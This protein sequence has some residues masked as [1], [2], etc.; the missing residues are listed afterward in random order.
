MEPI[1]FKRKR[2]KKRR[3]QLNTRKRRHS[4]HKN[5]QKG[6]QVLFQVIECTPVLSISPLVVPLPKNYTRQTVHY[7]HPFG[8][9]VVKGHNIQ[10]TRAHQRDEISRAV[11]YSAVWRQGNNT[12]EEIPKVMA[13]LVHQLG[14]YVP[15]RDDPLGVPLVIDH[16]DPVDLLRVQLQYDVLD[17]I[18]PS[19]CDDG[20]EQRRGLV[21]LLKVLPDR[22]KEILGRDCPVVGSKRLK[23]AVGFPT[24]Y[25]A[26]EV[27]LDACGGS[28][29]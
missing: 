10:F 11:S 9:I 20:A 4:H 29:S 17:F 5:I 23:V 13:W 18:I 15:Q 16:V 1:F 3:E 14:D 6:A 2:K 22:G 24:S 27:C 8:T 21:L 7:S 25:N 12:I 28:A 19:A 26:F